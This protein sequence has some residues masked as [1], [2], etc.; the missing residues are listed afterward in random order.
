VSIL[1]LTATMCTNVGIK[2]SLGSR[3]DDL[4]RPMMSLPALVEAGEASVALR[5]D[6]LRERVENLRWLKG[7]ARWLI[8]E[9]YSNELVG[10]FVTWLNI[11]FLLDVNAFVFSL[12][13]LRRSRA[14]LRAVFRA[15]GTLDA[16]LAIAA[17][18]KTLPH[19]SYPTFTS[20]RRTLIGEEIFH[21]LLDN[22]V[23][24]DVHM[25]EQSLLITGSNM[26]GKSTYLRAIGTCAVMA[27]TVATVPAK[28][29]TAPRL[30]VETLVQRRDDLDQGTSYF[31][32]EAKRVKEMLDLATVGDPCI[33]IIDE[34]YRG[35]NTAERV[36]AGSAVLQHLH[37]AGH[38]CAV[39]THDLELL[40]ILGAEW[41]RWYFSETVDL[42]HLSFDYAVRSGVSQRPNALRLLA[43]L[44]YPPEVVERAYEAHRTLARPAES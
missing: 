30:R 19:C 32:A 8:K 9:D 18:R 44:R 29:W 7:S 1:V 21:P 34:L 31:L 38:L 4:I 10:S 36:A 23:V 13:R 41:E 15:V 3:L 33:F 43:H 17:Y 6:D 12:D 14:D 24:N 20:D 37:R 28:S 27:Q 25:A 40:T 11:L 26:S 35:T 16:L 5:G 39:A 22:P 42:D 2:M